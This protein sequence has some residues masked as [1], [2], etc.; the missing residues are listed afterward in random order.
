MSEPEEPAAPEPVQAPLVATADTAREDYPSGPAP[1]E[2]GAT[3]AAV[4][5][6]SA[7]PGPQPTPVAEHAGRQSRKTARNR[8]SSVPSWDEIM[9]GSSR[10]RD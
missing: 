1:A 5:P 2:S 8:R 4:Q 6:D 9:F 7:A 3:P 10:Q